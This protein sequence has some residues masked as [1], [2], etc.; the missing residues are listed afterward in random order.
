[1]TYWFAPLLGAIDLYPANY[2][3]FHPH[4]ALSRGSAVGETVA[5]DPVSWTA[6]EIVLLD[7]LIGL[8]QYNVVGR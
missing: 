2:W 3:R 4:L 8:T 1:M 5:I 6:N 7:S